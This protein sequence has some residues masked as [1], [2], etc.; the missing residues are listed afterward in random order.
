MAQPLTGHGA[1]ATAVPAESAAPS[2][3]RP[4]IAPRVVLIAGGGTGGHLMPAL[5]L[6]ATLREAAPELEP[7]LV[8]AVRGVEARILP[9]RDFRYHLLPVE[10]IYRRQWWK[11]LR[12]PLIAGRIINAVEAVYRAER[13]V[14]V[15][16]TG[17]YASGP[18]VW[19]ARRRGVPSAVQEQNAYPGLATRWLAR[20]VDHVYLGIPEARELLKPGK[21]TQLFDTGNPIVPPD[22]ARRDAAFRRFGLDGR[23][24]VVLVTGGSQGA[25]AIN[26]A[27]A[28][29][30]RAGGPNGAAVIWV[31]GR[32]THAEFAEF[33]APPDV[34]VIDFL[35]PMADAYAVA[36]LVVSRAGMIT[37]AEISA[38]GL[39]SILIPLPTAAADHQTHNARAMAQAGAAAVLPQSE[40]ER[41][42]LGPAIGRLLGDGVAAERMAA[43]ARARGRPE[44]ARDIVSLLLTLIRPA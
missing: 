31:T 3:R 40:M 35:D 7:V 29:W 22:P 24:R 37:V 12:W 41:E 23:R 33:H 30:I 17:G 5:A 26:R 36:D 38:W 4:S 11:N 8:G 25:L 39:P 28:E 16:G 43:A 2:P 18:V 10:P 20:R 27:V 44:A 42:G 1:S 21:G 13:P 19:L 15:L 34:Q 9:T 6:A 32:G 14:A